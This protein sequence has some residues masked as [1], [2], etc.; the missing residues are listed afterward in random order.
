MNIKIPFDAKHGEEK[1]AAAA[2]ASGGEEEIHIKN[3]NI[4]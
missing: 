3:L 4:I 1:R 2:A